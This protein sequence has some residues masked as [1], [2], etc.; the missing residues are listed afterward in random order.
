MLH[1]SGPPLVCTFN[2]GPAVEVRVAIPAPASG[3]AK[4]VWSEYTIPV[5]DA[6]LALS[7]DGN[8]FSLLELRG[9]A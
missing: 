2:F 1:G 7:L 4:D 6:R 8:A 3:V 5:R 9:D